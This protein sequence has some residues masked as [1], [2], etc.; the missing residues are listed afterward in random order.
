MIAAATLPESGFD[1]AIIRDSLAELRFGHDGLEQFL[2]LLFD[3]LDS[4]REELDEEQARLED[5]RHQLREKQAQITVERNQWE[6]D[7]QH[8]H[9]A[10]QKRVV[11]LEKDRLAL[12]ADLET[13]RR[14][15]EETA[16][17]FAAQRRQAADDHADLSG[18]LRQLRMLLDAKVSV[19]GLG[20][21]S[22]DLDDEPSQTNETARDQ[23]SKSDSP[24]V[25]R[26]RNPASQDCNALPPRKKPAPANPSQPDPVM[27]PLLS[28][29]QMLQRDV[30]RRREKKN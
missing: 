19:G 21:A 12:A 9:D 25:N 6:T 2:G 8:W 1:R 30:A 3:E 29:F 10:L 24:H 13:E 15:S 28:Q 7:R 4:L 17:D 22:E 18:E 14:R 26:E 27:G 5:E 16:E 11:E 20:P 23:T